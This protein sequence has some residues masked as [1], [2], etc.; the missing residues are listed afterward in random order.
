MVDRGLWLL[1]LV[2]F[3]RSEQL[4]RLMDSQ[5]MVMYFFGIVTVLENKHWGLH[6]DMFLRVIFYKNH[7]DSPYL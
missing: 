3:E 7:P 5:T 6:L 1:N 2:K 4:L